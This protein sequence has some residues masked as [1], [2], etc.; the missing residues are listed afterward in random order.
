[1]NLSHNNIS[2]L[3]DSISLLTRLSYLFLENNVLCLLPYSIGHLTGMKELNLQDNFLTILPSSLGL[4]TQL[5]SLNLYGNPLTMFPQTTKLWSLPLP[6][7][8]NYLDDF[9]ITPTEFEGKKLLELRLSNKNLKHIPLNVMTTK[10]VI[11]YVQKE[12]EKMITNR[13]LAR[14]S[15]G[16]ESRSA[17]SNH[18]GQGTLLSRNF[19]KVFSRAKN[20][21]KRTEALEA[22]KNEESLDMF[23]RPLD[24]VDRA[25]KTGGYLTLG[26]EKVAARYKDPGET[27]QADNEETLEESEADA[28]IGRDTINSSTA[29]DVEEDDMK[30]KKLSDAQKRKLDE[31]IM[32]KISGQISEM[33]LRQISG[34]MMSAKNAN[35]QDTI[36]TLVYD[37]DIL[38]LDHNEILTLPKIIYRLYNTSV[39]N[40]QF[41]FIDSISNEFKYLSSLTHLRLDTN[42]VSSISAEISRL[43]SLSILNLSRNMIQYD[44]LNSV[45]WDKMVA[46]TN[47]DLSENSISCNHRFLPQQMYLIPKLQVFRLVKCYLRK[48]PDPDIGYLTQ[49]RELDLSYNLFTELCFEFRHLRH[50]LKKLICEQTPVSFPDFDVISL[51]PAWTV[52]KLLHQMW[53][54]KRNGMLFVQKAELLLLPMVVFNWETVDPLQ[55]LVNSG[56]DDWD[57]ELNLDVLKHQ[58]KNSQKLRAA[59]ILVMMANAEIRE[60]L[61]SPGFHLKQLNLVGNHIKVLPEEISRLRH[62]NDLNV[63][64]NELISVPSSIGSLVKLAYIDFSHN[65]LQALPDELSNN[66]SLIDFRCTHNELRYIPFK[67]GS[68]PILKWL[69]TSFNDMSFP[70]QTTVSLGP[71]SV[72]EFMK[73]CWLEFTESNSL[74]LTSR[75]IVMAPMGLFKIEN[76]VAIDLSNNAIVTLPS[77]IDSASFLNS[78]NLCNNQLISIPASI[79]FLTELT[80]LYL[81]GNQMRALPPT[82]A[83]CKGLRLLDIRS[84]A[85]K[86]LP[87]FVLRAFE[88]LENL[89]YS[90]NDIRHIDVADPPPRLQRLKNLKS[91]KNQVSEFFKPFFF[92]TT[93]IEMDFSGNSL[94]TI[95]EELHTLCNLINLNLSMNKL[96]R[97]SKNI[98]ALTQLKQ[99]FLQCNHIA[100]LVPSFQEL[101]SLQHL[102]LHE[103]PLKKCPPELRCLTGLIRL[104]LSGCSMNKF[105]ENIKGKFLT[106]LTMSNNALVSLPVNVVEMSALR[107][108]VFNSNAVVELPSTIHRMT[109]LTELRLSNNSISRLP[110]TLFQMKQLV[111]LAL[112]G[113]NIA[114]L[115]MSI[116]GLAN[117]E[118]LYLENNVL[119]EMP[120]TIVSLQMLQVLNVAENALESLPHVRAAPFAVFHR[121]HWHGDAAADPV[122]RYSCSQI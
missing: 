44:T 78:L 120:D 20:D 30:Y 86:T 61:A 33:A 35:E 107:T 67:M 37:F 48:N 19:L 103:N 11:K 60:M 84:N 106:I 68:L 36:G 74:S 32:L 94:S 85:F 81:K 75:N 51:S 73:K 3:P 28:T 31:N 82:L 113:N 5:S 22:L 79:G 110:E 64:E 114:K 6:M 72:V 46:L 27:L 18:F 17:L 4:C 55:F 65:K 90:E 23:G 97:L 34:Q 118:E 39:M 25:I 91:A 54:A 104:T 56:T 42:R 45:S 50:C 99:L 121:A 66:M 115:D 98:G 83:K 77:Q 10:E 96:K 70:P 2:L 112:N 58:I 49:L 41:N 38:H 9:L 13:I 52:C 24:L 122:C 108:L 47:L 26:I 12:S 76:L 69:D 116:G 57:S 100:E 53:L 16:I 95:P 40:L 21:T 71:L 59:V 29:D 43:T 119:Y 92:A 62:L 87:V 7:L 101:H 93:I 63:S 105:D 89:W 1:L 109:S 80:Y 8:F 102:K 14:V 88:E 117:L 111:I 15:Q